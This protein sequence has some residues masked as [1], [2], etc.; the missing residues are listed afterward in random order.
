MKTKSYI[1]IGIILLLAIFVFQN[2]YKVTLHFLFWDYEILLSG[3][4]LLSF[5]LGLIIGWI[6]R[7]LSR[8]A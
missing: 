4:I 2:T 7:I 6:F 3:V 1:V 5:A 8:K